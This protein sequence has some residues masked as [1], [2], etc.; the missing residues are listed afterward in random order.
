MVTG[1]QDE[2]GMGVI[3]SSAATRRTFSRFGHIRTLLYAHLTCLLECE[4]QHDSSLRRVE[5]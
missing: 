3:G 1:Q 4:D 5:R 2:V